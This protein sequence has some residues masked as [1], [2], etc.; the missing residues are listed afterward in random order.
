VQGQPTATAGHT[1][2]PW[3][4]IGDLYG[5]DDYGRNRRYTDYNALWSAIVQVKEKIAA[6][7]GAERLQVYAPYL[8]GC[9]NA[10]GDWQTVYNTILLPLL[11][12]A[13]LVKYG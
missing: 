7:P 8:L 11:P 9:G 1:A 5:Q 13:T 10:G 3:V 6:T 2:P 12:A 4:L